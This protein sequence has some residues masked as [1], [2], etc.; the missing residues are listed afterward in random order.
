MHKHLSILTEIRIEDKNELT[1]SP[2]Q[3]IKMLPRRISVSLL[4]KDIM[5]GGC[6]HHIDTVHC[7][8]LFCLFFHRYHLTAPL[9]HLSSLKILYISL[10]FTGS[11][12]ILDKIRGACIPQAPLILI[13]SL[14]LA[15]LSVSRDSSVTLWTLQACIIL[16]LWSIAT[17]SWEILPP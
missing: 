4:H 17:C 11:L 10:S 9:M 14:E 13:P 1:I 7:S 2:V 5:G 8:G 15:L 3:Q 16:V 12:G 6:Y